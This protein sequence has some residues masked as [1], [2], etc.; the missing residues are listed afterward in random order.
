MIHDITCSSVPRS[1]AGMSRSGPITSITSEVYRRVMRWSSDFDS[2]VGS[3]HTPPLAPPKG[4]FISA[5]FQDIHMASAAT[6]P[7]LTSSA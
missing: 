7:R 6:S 5:H 4:R 3:T 1:G 2:C